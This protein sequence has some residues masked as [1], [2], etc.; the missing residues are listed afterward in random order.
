MNKLYACFVLIIITL[1]TVAIVPAQAAVILTVD[2][3]DFFDSDPGTNDLRFSGVPGAH[4]EVTVTDNGN[5]PEL[6]LRDFFTSPK[7]GSGET[8]ASS[9]SLADFKG[10]TYGQ[11]FLSGHFNPGFPFPPSPEVDIPNT[12]L[13]L[14]A[15]NRAH[16]DF[17]TTQ[18]ALTGLSVFDVGALGFSASDFGTGGDLYAQD[19]PFVKIGQWQAVGFNV[20]VAFDVKPQACPNPLVVKAKGRLRVAILGTENL[21]VTQVDV[22]TIKLEGVSPLRSAI[23]DV[24]TPFEP[25]TGKTDALDCTDEGPDGFP[26]LSLKFDN[27]AVVA[28]LSPVTD[29]EVR[30][31]KLTGNLMDGTTI[32]GEDVVVILN[33]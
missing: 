12:S 5:F 23:K 28:A 24:Q 19:F 1:T 33:K 29:E 6:D 14:L 7:S 15:T 26:D 10:R 30:V 3:S 9:E 18:T 8:S 17:D 21:D 11:R 2:V 27:P 4:P 20:T 16:H 31:L 25:F 32:V 22:D 13:G